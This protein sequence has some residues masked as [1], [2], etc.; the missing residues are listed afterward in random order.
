M[1]E[2]FRNN[3]FGTARP[4]IALEMAYMYND[5]YGDR[6]GFIKMNFEES[7]IYRNLSGPA[8]CTCCGGD[9]YHDEVDPSWT[10]CR[11]CSGMYRCDECGS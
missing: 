4:Y 1:I 11:E 2:N 9:I 5:I 3:V 6:L 10:I 8:V 7:Y